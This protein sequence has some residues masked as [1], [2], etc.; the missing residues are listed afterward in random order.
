MVLIYNLLLIN[1]VE[2][3]FISLMYLQIG[4]LIKWLLNYFVHFSTGSLI[5]G[6]NFLPSFNMSPP[7]V[8]HIE[9]IFSPSVT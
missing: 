7:S 9:N 4:A 2:H 6:Q 1:E 8:V 5:I 3:V